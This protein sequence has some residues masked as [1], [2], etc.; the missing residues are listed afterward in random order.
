MLLFGILCYSLNETQN[1]GHKTEMPF[2]QHDL[3]ASVKVSAQAQYDVNTN[4]AAGHG[5]ER[6][7]LAC[8]ISTR[9]A[10]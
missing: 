10:F 1:A 6:R 2:F 8:W 5:C 9:K 7:V 3:N 4:A